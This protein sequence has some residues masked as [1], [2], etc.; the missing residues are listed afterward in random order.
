MTTHHEELLE[1]AAGVNDITSS[2]TSVKRGLND[3]D[4]SLDKYIFSLYVISFIHVN[5]L[6]FA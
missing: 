5:C 2:L 6:D 3:L 1:Q 4:A